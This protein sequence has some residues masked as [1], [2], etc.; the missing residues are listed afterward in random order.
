MFLF[1]LFCHTSFYLSYL[2]TQDIIYLI[3]YHYCIS[4]VVM[5]CQEEVYGEEFISTR[6]VEREN[7]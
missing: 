7:F 6:T 2:V 4:V 5:L 1:I 3:L